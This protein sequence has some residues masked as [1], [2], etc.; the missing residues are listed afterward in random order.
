MTAKPFFKFKY[1]FSKLER[2]LSKVDDLGSYKV[3]VGIVGDKSQRKEGDISNADLVM[4]HEHGVISRNIPRRS[5]FDSLK[6]KRKSLAEDID[7][8]F[9]ATVLNSQ[10][11]YNAYVKTGIAMLNIVKGS[12]D[13]EG[14]GKWQPNALS[15]IKK[16]LSKVPLSKQAMAQII[17]MVDTGQLERALTYRVLKWRKSP[18]TRKF[19]WAT[20][21]KEF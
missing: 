14:Y 3:Q 20:R 2:F 16:K 1:D 10:P 4:I 12:F 6:I 19:E 15:T 7:K 9:K 21:F 5:I 8:I 17:T 13:T 18:K 11:V